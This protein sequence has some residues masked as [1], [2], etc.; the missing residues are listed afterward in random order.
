MKA[1]QGAARITVVGNARISLNLEH[2]DAADSATTVARH[3]GAFVAM[4]L[5][6]IGSCDRICH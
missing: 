4:L 3:G 1:Y 6:G 5:G 2:F